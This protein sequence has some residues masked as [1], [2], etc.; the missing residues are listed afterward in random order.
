MRVDVFVPSIPFYDEAA[1]TR[2]RSGSHGQEAW[3]LSAEATAV[4]KLL[5]FRGKDIVDLERLVA[6]QGTRLD[7]GY[8]RRWMVDMVGEDDERVSKWDELVRTFGGST[9]Q[10]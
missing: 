5:F 3:F 1:R 10:G 4:F 6:V 7:H 8:V 2:V 9:R